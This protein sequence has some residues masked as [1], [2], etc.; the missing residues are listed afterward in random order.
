MVFAE[1]QHSEVVV[2][3]GLHSGV[4]ASHQHS[5]VQYP[6]LA[7]DCSLPLRHGGHDHSADAAQG[8][9]SLQPGK[10]RFRRV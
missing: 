6:Q 7:D 5:L 9:R 2:E 4:D 1:K 10:R 3:M 8:H